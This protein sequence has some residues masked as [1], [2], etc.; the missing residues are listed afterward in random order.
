MTGRYKR[1]VVCGATLLI[2]TLAFGCWLLG[3]GPELAAPDKG[4]ERHAPSGPL[5]AA[6]SDPAVRQSIEAE[7]TLAVVDADGKPI[8][9]CG[10][11]FG[12]DNRRHRTHLPE[13]RYR[14]DQQGVA[15]FSASDCG[16]SISL[17]APGFLPRRIGGL[18]PGESRAE[19]LERG[20]LVTFTVKD[21]DGQPLP[22]ALVRL[23]RAPMA[24][25]GE[26]EPVLLPGDI[27]ATAIYTTDSNS[28][29]EAAVAVPTGVRLFADVAKEGWVVL[30]GLPLGHHIDAPSHHDLRMGQIGIA[31]V[32]IR[33]DKVLS[34]TIRARSTASKHPMMRDAYLKRVRDRLSKR[35][36]N[37]IVATVS[38]TDPTQSAQFSALLYH[39]GSVQRT[40][41]ITP[42]AEFA[43]PLL[44]DAST[45]PTTG[46]YGG[47]I[48]VE[49]TVEGG[50]EVPHSDLA[51]TPAEL[52]FG[53]LLPIR[54]GGIDV[55]VGSYGLFAYDETLRRALAEAGVTSLSAG[56][57]RT[58]RHHVGR[59]LRRVELD[60]T[61]ED[62]E[63]L[64]YGLMAV[65]G[66]EN[67]AQ[68]NLTFDGTMRRVMYLPPQRVAYRA[69]AP[70][71]DERQGFFDIR[72]ATERRFG[73]SLR[74][75]R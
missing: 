30:D 16:V 66:A 22:G 72:D 44:I 61:D 60:L 20:A 70:G 56:E 49:V 24:V 75:I 34:A 17:Y 2:A 58:I 27:H 19:T 25:H 10:V 15:H 11:H 67:V 68:S 3:D 40:L 73:V 65:G 62:G 32:E 31:A 57:S 14:T 48:E 29:G 69:S 36:P 52:G 55:P 42:L 47:R 7:T 6:A 23:S 59:V 54:E 64:A 5:T 4:G 12:L 18:H 37:A 28:R 8:S 39:K 63:A 45:M 51:L 53:G 41:P 1:V 33:G 21:L 46:I 13:P 35:F 9:H 71:H 50:D 38:N 26:G 74:R 43:A